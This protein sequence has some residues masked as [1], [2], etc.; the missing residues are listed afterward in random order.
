MQKLIDELTMEEKVHLYIV[1]ND[2]PWKKWEE[3]GSAEQFKS[4]LKFAKSLN[5][6]FDLII[7][8]GR[9]RVSVR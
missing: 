5:Q 8:D 4:Y 1:P 6:K 9:A 2:L 7:D 3:D